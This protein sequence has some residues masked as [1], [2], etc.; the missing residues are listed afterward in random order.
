MKISVLCKISEKKIKRKVIFELSS[1][2]DWD[3]HV[4]RQK[5]AITMVKNRKRSKMPNKLKSRKP[6]I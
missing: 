5:N 6:L 2:R 3:K 1:E 4:G